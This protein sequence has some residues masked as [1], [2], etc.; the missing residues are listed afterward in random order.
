MFFRGYRLAEGPG[1]EVLRFNLSQQ[2]FDFTGDA[3]VN[4]ALQ[5]KGVDALPIVKVD[6]QIKSQGGA[7]PSREQ[8]AA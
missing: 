3:L 4:G 5:A 1:V 7:Y 8:L 2:P 6:G